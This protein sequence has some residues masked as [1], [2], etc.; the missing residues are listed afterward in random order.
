MELTLSSLDPNSSMGEDGLNPRLLINPSLELSV[1]L[2]I[3]FR[4]S[5]ETGALPDHWLSS[6]KGSRYNS[7]N[8]RPISITSV[9]CKSLER[10]IV[11]HIRG[12][13]NDN[14]ILSGNQY[15]FHPG[16]STT[17]QLLHILD[18]ITSPLDNDRVVDLVFLILKRNSIG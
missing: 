10:I 5:F 14:D 8:Y 13:L 2:F 17:D 16:Y 18:H 12:Y 6:T 7:L 3:L 15:G 4:A 1:P 9:A 11:S